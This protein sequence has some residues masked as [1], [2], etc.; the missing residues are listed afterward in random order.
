MSNLQFRTVRGGWNDFAIDLWIPNI[1]CWNLKIDLGYPKMH[2]WGPKIRLGGS[3]IDFG[4]PKMDIGVGNITTT[5]VT[6]TMTETWI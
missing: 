4:L 6:T 5:G 1:D 2:V 3:N